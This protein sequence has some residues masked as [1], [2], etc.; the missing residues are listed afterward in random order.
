MSEP[1]QSRAM[2]T[3]ARLVLGHASPDPV[4]RGPRVEVDAAGWAPPAD[5]A[6]RA[7]ARR[8]IPSLLLVLDGHGPWAMLKAAQAV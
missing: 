8:V 3:P 5:P 4:K 2:P 1:Y 6:D 7:R